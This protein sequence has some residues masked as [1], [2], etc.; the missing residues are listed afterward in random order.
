MLAE[1]AEASKNSWFFTDKLLKGI[2]VKKKLVS[3]GHRTGCGRIR[4]PVQLP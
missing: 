3:L 4:R 1:A 2:K